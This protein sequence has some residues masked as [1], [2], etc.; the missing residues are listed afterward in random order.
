M[1]ADVISSQMK[2]DENFLGWRE[3]DLGNYSPKSY[4]KI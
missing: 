2:A 1:E 4:K 3:T